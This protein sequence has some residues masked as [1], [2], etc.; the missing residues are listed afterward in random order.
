MYS[1]RKGSGTYTVSRTM[2]P[3]SFTAI[4][5]HSE[6]SIGTVLDYYLHFFQIRD[7]YLGRVLSGLNIYS[8]NFDLLPLQFTV[9]D[10]M[11]NE[12]I[13][14]AME[15]MLGIE[16]LKERNRIVKILV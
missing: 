2:H 3:P 8:N 9:L 14:E 16:F 1:N 13:K 7:Q 6:W 10:A 15:M 12:Y 5:H 4:A 11:S